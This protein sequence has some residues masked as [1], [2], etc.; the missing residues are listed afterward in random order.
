MNTTTVSQGAAAGSVALSAVV[1]IQWM[2]SLARVSMPADVATAVA[3]LLTAGVHYLIANH[4][5][6]DPAKPDAAPAISTTTE[7]PKV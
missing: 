7:Q 6:P 3:V 2:L 1:L 4:K 5:A